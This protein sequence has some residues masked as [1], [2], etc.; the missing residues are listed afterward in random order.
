M[1]RSAGDAALLLDAIA[2]HDPRDPGSVDGPTR[3]YSA[4]IDGGLR[5]LRVGFV[6][7]FHERDVD[8]DP[9]VIA[10]LDEAARVL[11]R[12]GATV[13]EVELPPLADFFGSQRV[14]MAS[15]AWAVHARWLRSRPGDYSVSSRRRLMA[16]AFLAAGDYVEAQQRRQEL[17]TAVGAVAC[18]VDVLLVVNA[19]DPPCRIDD[20]E[21]I[22]RTYTRQARNVFS[23][24]GQPALAL[25]CG[26]SSQ[27]LPLSMQLAARAHDEATVL[28]VGAAFER[29][30]QWQQRRPALPSGLPDTAN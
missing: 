9:E 11:A 29:A 16:G 2:G 13:C 23:L 14:I 19:M 20:A 6:R 15:E 24:T 27:G 28:R 4:S 25:M 22:A 8:A 26:L 7:R 17:I 1:A 18:E 30:T 5:G 21:Q 12:E 3:N 10:A